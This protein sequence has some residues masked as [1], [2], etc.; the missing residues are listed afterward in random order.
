M[1]AAVRVEDLKVGDRVRIVKDR[2]RYFGEIAKIEGKTLTL[3][4]RRGEQTVAVD[5]A[6]KITTSVKGKFEDLKVGKYVAVFVRE[7]KAARIYLREGPPPARR[8]GRRG[9]R[10]DRAPAE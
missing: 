7:G 9:R 8:G 1:D 10:R 2:K 4:R 6:T 5:D 3:K